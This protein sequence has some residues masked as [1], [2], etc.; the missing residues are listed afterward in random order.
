MQKFQGALLVIISS[1]AFG[2]MAVLAPLAYKA[3]ATPITLLFLRFLIAGVIMVG[4]MLVRRI[5]FPHGK[6]LL[7]L[8]AIGG[9]WYVAQTLAYFTALSMT[10]AGL[11]G[12]LLYLY[13]AIVALIGAIA[14][15]ERLSKAKLGALGLA[16]LGTAFTLKPD[17]DGFSL[18]IVLALTAAFLYAGYIVVG[19][20]LMEKVDIRSATAVIM[21][22]TGVSFGGIVAIRGFQAPNEISGWVAI[23][24]TV[25]CS[26]IAL[27]TFFAGLEKVGS[28]NAAILSTTEPFVTV[29]LAAW[30]LGERLEFSQLL[31]G[32]LILF[33]VIFLTRAGLEENQKLAEN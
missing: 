29:G 27:G 18:G 3:G 13:P 7:G 23:A 16:L 12:L 33:A 24:A 8:I 5:P 2:T 17:G 14:F 31:G 6:T 1:I 4:W 30:W 28:T 19:G 26:I 25:I 15:R 20:K 32:I 10:A 21:L 22:S 9:V 11:V